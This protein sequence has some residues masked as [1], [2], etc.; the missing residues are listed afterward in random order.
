MAIAASAMKSSPVY[1]TIQINGKQHYL[2]RAVERGG[3]VIDVF[4]QARRNGTAATRFSRRLLRNHGAEL[5]KIET[6]KL[7]S[8]PAAH[9]DLMTDV[10]H[11]RDQYANNRAEHSHQPTRVRERCMRKFKSVKQAQRFLSVHAAVYN[12]FN[13]GRHLV[14]T[15]T[16]R[17]PRARS[18]ASWERA[19]M[20]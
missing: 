3:E 10:I 9:R 7:R 18:F 4:L 6:D 20:V 14:S 15:E 2:W 8:Y 19:A 16:Y 17:F 12:L 11:V 1:R 5:R 13:L